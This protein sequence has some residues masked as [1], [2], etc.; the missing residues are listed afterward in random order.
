MPQS[1]FS[2]FPSQDLTPGIAGGAAPSATLRL[3]GAMISGTLSAHLPTLSFIHLMT[4]S[5]IP[6]LPHSFLTHPLINWLTHSHSHQLTHSLI[7][8]F[9]NSIRSFISSF[10]HSFAHPPILNH[11]FMLIH[12]F[13]FLFVH[14]LTHLLVHLHPSRCSKT[15]VAILLCPL[16]SSGSLDSQGQPS[17][18]LDPYLYMFPEI[19]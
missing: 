9:A 13:V 7:H 12:P 6:S 4:H 16:S 15:L 5:F 18:K 3:H 2:N 17:R 19:K 11:S 14:L 10:I 1:P 8:P